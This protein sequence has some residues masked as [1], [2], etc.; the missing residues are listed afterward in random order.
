VDETVIDIRH[1]V[2]WFV[3]MR[4]QY[5]LTKIVADT[6]R[7]DLVRT[8]LEAEG[9]ELEFIRN[10]KAIHSLLAPRVE[11]LFAKNN[12]IFDDNPLMRWYTNNVYVHIK[13]DGNKEYLKKDE[14]RRKTDGFQAFSHALFKADE[15]LMD[16]V[17]FFLDDIDF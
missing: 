12:I 9:F 14:F 1:I 5:G 13:K 4:E 6:F 10:P 7:L 2:N 11:I 8:A 16:D 15:I 17:D 3:E